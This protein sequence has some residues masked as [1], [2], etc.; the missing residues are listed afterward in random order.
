VLDLIP[1]V[2]RDEWSGFDLN[3][4]ERYVESLLGRLP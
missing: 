1:E 4:L 2:D 3:R